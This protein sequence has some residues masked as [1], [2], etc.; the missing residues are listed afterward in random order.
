MKNRVSRLIKTLISKKIL[1]W[2]VATWLLTQ[3]YIGG[4]EW[5]LLTCAVFALDLATKIKAPFKE[6]E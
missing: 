4:Q 6:C 1:A 5:V 2:A 3:G